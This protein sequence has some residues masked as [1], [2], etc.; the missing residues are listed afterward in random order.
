M[1]VD[2]CCFRL[3]CTRMKYVLMSTINGVLKHKAKPFPYITYFMRGPPQR[4][5]TRSSSLTIC[6]P[7]NYNFIRRNIVERLT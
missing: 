2:F 1:K 4:W 5:I 3:T 6:I 7:I